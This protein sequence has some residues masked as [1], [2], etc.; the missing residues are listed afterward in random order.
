MEVKRFDGDGLRYLVVEPDG[1][2]RDREYPLVVL[3]HGYGSH[4]GDLAAL[5]EMIDERGYVYAFPNGP[6]RV[7][8]GPGAV[9]YGW[10]AREGEFDPDG[11]AEGL[12]G[13][14]IDEVVDRY[15]IAEGKIALG[16]FSQ[17]GMMAYRHGLAM[18][19]VFGG[20]A[21]LSARIPG[22]RDM[23]EQLPAV[24]DQPVFIAHGTL[25]AMIGVEMGRAARDFLQANGYA[26]E[27]HEYEMAHQIT[28]EVL[29]DLTAWVH[30]V[31][32]P[33]DAGR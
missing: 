13:T 15:D 26:P 27:H 29:A 32:P 20:V 8:L 18:P 33:A 11:E 17:G 9:G 7:P 19:D 25:D 4:M 23:A 24:R 12:V 14:F 30:R 28:A 2:T 21:A 31:L 22:R 16:G 6:I 1:Y 5:S 10:G 3:L